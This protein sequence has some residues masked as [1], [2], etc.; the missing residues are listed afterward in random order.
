MSGHSLTGLE[1]FI[2]WPKSAGMNIMSNVQSQI[3][4]VTFADGLGGPFNDYEEPSDY[5][6]QYFIYVDGAG[7]AFDI[8]DGVE[9]DIATIDVDYSGPDPLTVELSSSFPLSTSWFV[10][11]YANP[12]HDGT[13]PAANQFYGDALRTTSSYEY[14]GTTIEDTQT[15]VNE[16]EN[17]AQHLYVKTFPNPATSSN[18]NLEVA[19]IN[20]G[21]S[22]IVEF[23]DVS[24]RIL[25]RHQFVSDGD[26]NTLTFSPNLP[27]GY[28][29]IKVS[30]ENQIA[31]CKLVIAE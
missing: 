4:G 8:A 16:I 29:N 23:F 15:G 24:G 26:S 31:H 17:I 2:R 14:E 21:K 25:H 19:G 5:Y 30:S 13:P 27:T 11:F 6:M 22:V 20:S 1:F 7:V 10:W 9:F 18:V 12:F 3:G 28:Y